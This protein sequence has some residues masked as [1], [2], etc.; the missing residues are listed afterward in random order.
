[1]GKTNT[2]NLIDYFVEFGFKPAQARLYFAGLKR[3]KSLMAE[4]CRDAIVP[5]STGYF[6]MD[7]LL[8]RGFFHTRKYGKRLYYIA[9]SG[10]RLLYETFEREKLIRRL[11]PK[12]QS[13]AQ[14]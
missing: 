6:L 3:G 14:K 7:E 12:L 9:A 13:L 10:E 5:R 8:R 4:L 11:L 1:M 2:K